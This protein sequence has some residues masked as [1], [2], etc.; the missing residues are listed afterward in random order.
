VEA[1]AGLLDDLLALGDPL[2]DQH[3]GVAA[4]LVEVHREGVAGPEGDQPRVLL[5][6]RLRDDRPRVGVGRRARHRLAAAE[7]GALLVDGAPVPSYWM[8]KF[9][10]HSAGS[11]V[12]SSISTTRKNG[13]RA[14]CLRSKMFTSRAAVAPA[15]SAAAIAASAMVR[16]LE[17]PLGRRSS[18]IASPLR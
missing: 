7:A 16:V 17:S 11:T 13:T 1:G 3:V 10:P 5:E 15:A 9:L 18:L 12:S 14:S 4:L 2:V 8:G 6:A